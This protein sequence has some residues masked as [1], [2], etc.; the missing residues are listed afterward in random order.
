MSVLQQADDN[1]NLLTSKQNDQEVCPICFDPS[2]NMIKLP[3]N[4]KFCISC[5]KSLKHHNI[6]KCPVCR[7][8][9]CYLHSRQLNSSTNLSTTSGVRPENMIIV[10]LNNT[11]L[12][13]TENQFNDFINDVLPQSNDIYDLMESQLL[14]STSESIVDLEE[15]VGI[16]L[17]IPQHHSQNL[18]LS[19]ENQNIHN[20]ARNNSRNNSRNNV[21]GSRSR[22]RRRN[23]EIRSPRPRPDVDE[24]QRRFICR[25]LL[26]LGFFFFLMGLLNSQN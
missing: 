4:H 10:Q 19:T 1:S 13:I 24:I 14:N 26:G 9:F 20:N 22:R 11:Y 15:I 23:G 25:F 17:I 21:R 16:P 2:T 5:I 8:P 7:E 18:L 3:C 12:H 6:M